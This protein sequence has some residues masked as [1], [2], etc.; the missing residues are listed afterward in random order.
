MNRESRAPGRALRG[1]VAVSGFTLLELLIVLAVASV[2]GA[3]VVPSFGAMLERN[4]VA[5]A[6]NE[7]LS[8]IYLLRSEAVKRNRIVKMCRRQGADTPRCDTS[9]GGGWHTGW[10]IWLDADGSNQID[11]GELVVSTHARLAGDLKLTG[12][13]SVASRI[14]FQPNGAT[15]GVGN[16]TFTVCMPG[17]SRK[18]QIIV[19]K[20][21]RIRTQDQESD[22]SC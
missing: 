21:G 3:M 19:S 15:H 5:A 1:A 9:D 8:S 4:R 20:A 7:F 18:R 22:G 12:S 11:E 2:L 10:L 13:G 14:A 6:N 17:G 16:G